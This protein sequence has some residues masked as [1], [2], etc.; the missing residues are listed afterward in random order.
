VSNL[1]LDLL[2]AMMGAKRDANLLEVPPNKWDY[3]IPH[4]QDGVPGKITT[5]VERLPL[6]A[7]LL[8]GNWYGIGYSQR[9]NLIVV[10][11]H[12]ETPP[13]A[14]QGAGGEGTH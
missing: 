8:D 10:S 1:E 9:A 11:R 5:D 2:R 6:K 14:G 13:D 7:C 12:T 3:Y 4:Y